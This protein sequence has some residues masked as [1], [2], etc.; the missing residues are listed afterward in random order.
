MEETQ[1][2]INKPT[3]EEIEEAKKNPQKRV[4]EDS[5]GNIKILERIYG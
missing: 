3:I 1:Q 4:V 5:E 2:E